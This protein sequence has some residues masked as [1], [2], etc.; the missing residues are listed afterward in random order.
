MANGIETVKSVVNGFTADGG[1]NIEGGLRVAYN[2]IADEV[3]KGTKGALNG[4]NDVHVIL[5]TDGEPTCYANENT[6]NTVEDVIQYGG[7]DEGYNTDFKDYHNAES[8]ASNL[9]N[10]SDK[11]VTLYTIAFATNNKFMWKA[12]QN[13]REDEI[14]VSEWLKDHIATSATT[15]Y[16]SSDNF[17]LGDIFDVIGKIIAVGA[18]AWRVTDNMGPNIIATNTERN[19]DATNVFEYSENNQVLNWNLKESKAQQTTAGEGDDAVKTYAYKLSYPILL[20]NTA[21]G[22]QFTNDDGSA[23]A[24]DTNGN[25]FLKYF[26][27]RRC[28]TRYAA[29]IYFEDSRLCCTCSKKL[30][31]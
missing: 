18:Q 11:S 8:V 28:N 7:T 24:H 21:D 19:N 27:F 17:N 3:A 29:R 13:D 25:T 1:T 22:F 26:F 4:I 15:A 31:W 14:T 2:L 9:R 12:N 5:L 10:Y 20:D 6:A 30:C 23:K 16:A